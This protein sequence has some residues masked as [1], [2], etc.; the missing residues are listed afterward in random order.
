[1]VGDDTSHIGRSWAVAEG[2]W[3]EGM[4]GQCASRFAV[5]PKKGDALLFY[6]MQPDG[7]LDPL[8][9]HGGCPVLN[10]TK[11][12]ANV[13]VWNGCRYGVCKNPPRS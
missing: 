8:S 2:G 12:A 13:W 4:D 6:S 1:M 9:W 3:E 11:W 5:P 10:G 7:A